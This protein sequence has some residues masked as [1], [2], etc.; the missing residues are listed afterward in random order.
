M[1][2]PVSTLLMRII[3]RGGGRFHCGLFNVFRGD[4]NG[5]GWR[6]AAGGPFEI[7]A[8]L[9]NAAAFVTYRLFTI[10]CCMTLG[11][12]TVLVLGFGAK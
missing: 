2:I 6:R 12:A 7:C 11:A 8:V 4:G 1:T 10:G 3:G 5:A 9:V